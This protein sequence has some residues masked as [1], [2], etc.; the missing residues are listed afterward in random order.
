[1]LKNRLIFVVGLFIIALGIKFGLVPFLAND[2]PLWLKLISALIILVT[3]AG[4]VITGTA[5]IIEETTEV[6]HDRT[7]IAGGLLQ[8]FGT[9]FP[10]MVLGIVAAVVSLKL[11]DTNYQLALNYAIIAAATTFGSNIYNI[12]HASWC[13]YR[14]NLANATNKIVLMFPGFKS[15]GLVRPINQHQL[16]PSRQEFDTAIGASVAL[17]ILTACVAVG[18]VIFGRVTDLPIPQSGDLYQLIRPVGGIVFVLA[19]GVLLFFRKSQRSVAQ[20]LEVGANSEPSFYFAKS[21]LI[22]WLSLI[23]AGAAIL[24][25]AE[26]MIYAIEMLS[27]VFKIPVVLAGVLSGLIGCLGEMTVVHNYSVNPNG[28]LGDA[29][30]GVAM[31]NIVTIVGASIV[32]MIGGIFFGGHALI[33]IF[34]LILTLNAILVGQMSQLKNYLKV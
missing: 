8:S 29:V 2:Q 19:L 12:G 10:D 15:A 16:Q 18:M 9:A 22:I 27:H 33:L 23:V 20:N 3:G 32:A 24:F 25:A 4:F 34:V 30:V 11:R 7:Q 5:K 21:N 6:L 14:Q 13:L 17:S 1:M 26:S 31:D 28:R